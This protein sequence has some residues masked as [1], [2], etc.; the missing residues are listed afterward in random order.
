MF[1]KYIISE[2][3]FCGNVIFVA[4][5]CNELLITNQLNLREGEKIRQRKKKDEWMNITA[6]IPVPILVNRVL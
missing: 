6:V 2:L 4:T 1:M 3:T 5:I